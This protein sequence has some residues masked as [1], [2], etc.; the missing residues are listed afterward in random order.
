MGKL[1]YD[2]TRNARKWIVGAQADTMDSG[3]NY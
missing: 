1:L 2:Q 3:D